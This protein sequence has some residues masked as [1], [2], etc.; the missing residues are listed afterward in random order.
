MPLSQVFHTPKFGERQGRT[1]DSIPLAVEST[2]EGR[3][4]YDDEMT[5]L[6]NR[7]SSLTDLVG[8]LLQCLAPILDDETLLYLLNSQGEIYREDGLG[9]RIPSPKSLDERLALLEAKE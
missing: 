9:Q 3:R 7:V 1:R 5:R 6:Q 4:R 2:V 8:G